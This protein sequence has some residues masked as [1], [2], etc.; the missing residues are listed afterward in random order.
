MN[1]L[2][3]WIQSTLYPTLFEKIDIVFKEHNFKKHRGD[4][5]SNTYLNGELHS[6][7]DKTTI[8]NKVPSRILEQGGESL[9]LIDY[10]M[11]RDSIE[12]I[13]ALK[14][15]SDTVGLTLPT[16]P[17][18]DKAAYE[19]LQQKYTLLELCNNY[20]IYYLNRSDKNVEERKIEKV[21]VFLK[22]RGYTNDD[23]QAM[24]LGYV[25]SQIILNKYLKAKG[26]SE[27]LIR[28]TLPFYMDNRI[29]YT[30]LLT[31]PY[32]SGGTLK[33]FKFRT[34]EDNKPKYINSYG[35]DKIGGFFNLLGIKGDKDVVIV[36]GELDSLHASIKGVDNVVATGGNSI[37]S[38]QIR[39]AINKGAKKFTLCF[40]TELNKDQST[41]NL[42]NRVIQI[43][44]EEGVNKVYIAT[45]PINGKKTDP[46]TFIKNNGIESF[47]KIINEALPYYLYQLQSIFNKYGRIEKEQE[48]SL[49]EKE[50]DNL[51][52]EVVTTAS[53]ISDPI[54]RDIFTKRFISIETTQQLGIT[55]K[56][57]SI[58]LDR[59]GYN[60]AKE[61]QTI[62]FK[63]L[64]SQ[65]SK[66]HDKGE[67][68]EALEL[69]DAKVKD[70]KLQDKATEFNNLLKPTTEKEVKSRHS[71]KIESLNS[72]YTIGGE[73]LSLPSGAIS[74][75]AAPT[76]HGKTTFLI[77]IALNVAQ[78]YPGKEVY[79]FSYEE[80]R[81]SILTNALNTYLN[82]E[83]SNN[84]RKTLK[85]YFTT[86]SK[87]YIRRESV[88]NFKYKKDEFFNRLIETRRLNIHYSNYNS[89]TLIEAIRYLY[90]NTNIGAVFIDYIQLLNLPQGKYKTYS[91]QE[92]I[93]EIC[94]ALKDVAVETGLPIILG[95]QFNRK[96]LNQ[97]HLH[98]T[99][100]G[101]AGDIERIANLIIGF[102][103]NNHKI[104]GGDGELN[105]IAAKGLNRPDTL[106]TE[107]LKNRGGRIGL[108]E[109]LEWN[110]NKGTI[111]N[112]LDFQ[113]DPFK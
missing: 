100:I 103:N 23:I 54:S 1:P 94:I 60:K 107:I 69:L 65:V 46:D 92:E 50:I 101:E 74:I 77:N 87:D 53:N 12:F 43:I 91:R 27:E 97:L 68:Q 42:I 73:E 45:L 64:L 62:E 86:G 98:P 5:R 13:E 105:E 34:V 35:L 31:I 8:T 93:K 17:S 47:K 6:R 79:L 112:S 108:T 85:S 66:L 39:D 7:S 71:K 28:E 58:T 38:S 102:W 63:H 36:E 49:T 33:G 32:R 30:H 70:I 89:D 57:L 81:D 20:F 96:V 109:L 44:Q 61:E 21:K 41:V 26:Y 67:T 40:D 59:I 99:Q 113:N 82:E 95:A 11:Q 111:K 56:S 2:T 76:S 9:S 48:R 52:E 4:W 90:K 88:E 14:R 16:D 3:E 22:N 83:I 72:G 24:E 84:N 19:K 78:Y 75:L 110:G 29:G 10:V 18:F 51:L 55:E 37:S 106:Y 80:D 15:L 104:T 25:P